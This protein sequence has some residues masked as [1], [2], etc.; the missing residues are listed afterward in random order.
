[1]EHRD[2]IPTC[3]NAGLIKRGAAVALFGTGP[4]APLEGLTKGGTP[5]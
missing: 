5:S 4:A 2:V 3:W 1:M